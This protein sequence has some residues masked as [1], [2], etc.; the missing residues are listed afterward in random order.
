[1]NNQTPE[2]L[3]VLS[4]E[5]LRPVAEQILGG[6][7]ERVAEWRTQG[8]SGGAAQHTGRG[9]GVH[10][11][12]GTAVLD[13]RSLPWTAVLKVAGPS[14]LAEWNRVDSV[15]YWKREV[16]VYQSDVLDDLPGSLV[17]PRIYAVQ[18]MP[19]GKFFIW[20][21]W[22]RDA[23]SDW[24]MAD[25]YLSARHL[26]QFNGGY[27]AGHAM[28]VQRPWMTTGR[29][30]QWVEGR[31]V[32]RDELLHFAQAEYVGRW[33]TTQNVDR[34]TKLYQHRDGLYDAIESLPVS[35]CHHD[36]FRRNL[37]LRRNEEGVPE[38]VACDWSYVGTGHLGQEIATTT[39]IDLMFLEVPSERALELDEAV[40]AG[41][42]DGLR[43]AGW[44]GDLRLPRLGYAA[45]AALQSGV[46]FTGMISAGCQT[47]EGLALGETIL[48][49]PRTAIADQLA[50]T[51][52]FLLDLGDEALELM[53]SI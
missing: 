27:V 13:G 20:L 43:D 44:Q 49:H 26:G 12:D 41:Y 30:R 40:F 9:Y 36:A 23:T 14:E 39:A 48:G 10:R 2:H 24:S 38:T 6:P 19:D 42:C 7:V 22:V 52:P 4:A 25:H 37:M 29:L 35:L 8:L 18:E 50:D 33:L 46:A 17:I 1:M 31:P 53:H 34:M 11:V 51:L 45:T 28:P 15:E 5:H 16:L 32:D 3:T 47:P 21:E